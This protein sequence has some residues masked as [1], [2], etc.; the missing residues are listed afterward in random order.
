MCFENSLNNGYITEKIFNAFFS[1]SIPIYI[2]PDD[3]YKYIH[4]N[5]FVDIRKIN[6]HKTASLVNIM[7]T[8]VKLKNNENEFIAFLNRRKINEYD[9]QNYIH[10]TKTFILDK[11][12]EKGLC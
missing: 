2:G 4:R 7:Q 10:K 8:I 9:D 1:K 6:D 12:K 11:M 3:I 5:S